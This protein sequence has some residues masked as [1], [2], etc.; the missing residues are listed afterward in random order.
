[1]PRHSLLLGECLREQGIDNEGMLM[2]AARCTAAAAHASSR[3]MPLAHC[4]CIFSHA[5]HDPARVTENITRTRGSMMP[6]VLFAAALSFSVSKPT[7]LPGLRPHV[8]A[9]PARLAQS[10]SQQALPRLQPHLYGV[11]L[12]QVAFEPGEVELLV[13]RVLKLINC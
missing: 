12:G 6:L 8:R 4:R 2:W 11:P 5:S 1:M 3:A 10:I 9:A 7:T 13:E